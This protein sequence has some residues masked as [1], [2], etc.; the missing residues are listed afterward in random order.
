MK[1]YLGYYTNKKYYPI[2]LSIDNPYDILSIV[3]FTNTFTSLENLQEYLY[4]IGLIPKRNIPLAY[5]IEKGKKGE[6]YYN[7]LRSGTTIYTASSSRYFNIQW[8]K[9]YFYNNKYDID[10]IVHLYAEY[11]RKF[12]IETKIIDL[13]ERTS[14]NINST[15]QLLTEIKNIAV[16]DSLKSLIEKFI[17]YLEQNFSDMSYDVY[18][19]LV[20]ELKNE[21]TKDSFDFVNVYV[22]LKSKIEVPN[23]PTLRRLS[24]IFF[25]VNRI[26]EI[27]L[28]EYE[29]SHD[30][31]HNLDL[32][33]NAF[34][35]TILY[36]FDPKNNDFRKENGKRVLQSR[37][38]F[39]LC[40]FVEAYDAYLLEQA[41]RYMIKTEDYFYNED[42]EFL[43]EADFERMHTTSEEQGIRLRKQ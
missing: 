22:R 16:T 33:L 21:I 41:S 29:N 23:I 34:F 7:A 13:L 28:S 38:I 4:M 19:R 3:K 2:T 35:E 12:G 43:E 42:D 25:I 30:E 15:Y 17:N 36:S 1:Y 9:D 11:L 39:D 14:N 31:Y 24:S 8:I 10:F 32:E 18:Y 6:K 26:K 20:E 37:N 40:V 27:G 5:V